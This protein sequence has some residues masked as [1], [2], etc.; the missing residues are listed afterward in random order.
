MT[1]SGPLHV[2]DRILC[3]VI[4]SVICKFSFLLLS[5]TFAVQVLALTKY[6]C[7]TG[8]VFSI[9]LLTYKL[10]Q[11]ILYFKIYVILTQVLDVTAVKG[12]RLRTVRV[13]P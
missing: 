6:F 3:S 4:L 13:D 9:T 10:N 11:I 7:F 2:F 8:C 12:Y 5:Q 1:A